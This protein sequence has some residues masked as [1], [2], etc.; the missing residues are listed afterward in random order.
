[1][2]SSNLKSI[3]PVFLRE[4]LQD[5]DTVILLLAVRAT[6]VMFSYYYLL[7]FSINAVN[8]QFR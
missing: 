7:Y 2:A 6:S 4:T 3:Y 8:P 1:M 5:S